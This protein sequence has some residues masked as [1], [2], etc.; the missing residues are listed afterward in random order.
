MFDDIVDEKN[1]YCPGILLLKNKFYHIPIIL[2]VVF[3]ITYNLLLFYVKVV[4]VMILNFCI[5]VELFDNLQ[6]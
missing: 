2:Y 4:G 5:H 3:E 1:G 6:P